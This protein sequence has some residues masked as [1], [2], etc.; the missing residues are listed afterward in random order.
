MYEFIMKRKV[1]EIAHY[2]AGNQETGNTVSYGFGQ[3]PN[4]AY[5]LRNGFYP[6]GNCNCN[7]K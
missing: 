7:Y 4:S 6:A 3:P 2:L 5:S 1:D